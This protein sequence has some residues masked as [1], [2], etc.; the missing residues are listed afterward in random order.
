MSYARI[1]DG[2][3]FAGLKYVC[4]CNAEINLRF[5]EVVNEN[6]HRIDART[7]PLIMAVKK[8]LHEKNPG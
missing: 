2:T 5:T 3:V 1:R 8:E 4:V 6:E 7:E